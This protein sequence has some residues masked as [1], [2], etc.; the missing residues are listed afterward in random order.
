MVPDVSALGKPHNLQV[1]KC[2]NAFQSSLSFMCM[3][4]SELLFNLGYQSIGTEYD[5]TA[6]FGCVYCCSINNHNNS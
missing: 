3:L 4:G 5:C 6:L 2:G 1:N